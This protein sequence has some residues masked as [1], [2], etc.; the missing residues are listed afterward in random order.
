M[1]R[2][3]EVDDVLP[4]F[5]PGEAGT[6]TIT[7]IDLFA[8]AGGLTAGLHQGSDRIRTVRAVEHDIAAAATFEENHGRNLVYA[9][10]IEEWLAEEEVPQVDLIVGGPPCQGFSQLNRN[11]V[12]VERNA[13]WEKYAVTISRAQPKWFVMENVSTFLK[14]REYQQLLSW[15][16]RN[17]IL[18][19]YVVDARVLLAA[20]YG[21]P[22]KRRR[23]VVIGH[24]R[25]VVAPGFP[26]PTHDRSTHLTVAQAF[27]NVRPAVTDI[28]LPHPRTTEFSGRS[29]PGPFRS[30]ELH[31]T[32]HYQELSRRRFRAI[33]AEGNRFDL[34]DMLK[35]P[36]WR[37]HTSGSGD[38][39]GRLYADRP[40]VTIRTEFFKPEKG[41]YLHPTEH[42]AITHFE[43]ARLQGFPDGYLWVGTKAEIARQ[44]GN[45]VPLALGRALGATIAQAARL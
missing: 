36:C 3:T 31:L 5:S 45:A 21:A 42:R 35:T 17:G 44:I 38:V 10:G 24:R 9:S 18:S 6:E 29:F 12:G 30:D 25:D 41:R 8:G 27:A 32:R 23:T 22:Q 14:A 43:A 34:P 16:E 7:S 15:T 11:R 20:D 28:D 39:M 19:N 37:A 1:K 13:L 4:P 2:L 40:S 26:A 33:P